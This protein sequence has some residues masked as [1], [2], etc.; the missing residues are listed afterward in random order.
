M[1]RRTSIRGTI[2]EVIEEEQRRGTITP[3]TPSYPTKVTSTPV[4]PV[5]V[6][7][8]NED[9]DDHLAD[10]SN[11]HQ[12]TADQ[13]GLGTDDSPTFAGGHFGGVANYTEFEADGTLVMHGDATVWDDLL[14]PATMTKM[15]GTKDPGFAV[16]KTNGSGSQGVFLYWFDAVT[17]EELYFAVQLPHSWAGT[18]ITPHVHWVPSIASDE[19]P[20]GQT[21]R[22]GLEYTWINID[23]TFA[24]TSIVYA[25]SAS[26]LTT[27]GKHL[28]TLF[29]A[30]TPG[31]GTQDGISSMLICRIFRDATSV[32]DD[33]Y[34]H[35]AGLLEIDFHYEKNTIGSRA[36][37]TK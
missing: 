23:G 16:F 1:I 37:G 36:A 13:V 15:G 11:P 14:V 20:S 19:N 33:T 6:P 25:K 28:M 21:V 3:V 34:E 30:I 31:A 24:N 2:R 22:W 8:T 17:E 18:P 35:D 32:A 12:V 29:S 4:T 26:G 27:A 5:T 9:L 7:A 10:T